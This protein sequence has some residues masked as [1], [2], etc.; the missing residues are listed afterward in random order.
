M[1]LLSIAALA[2]ILGVCHCLFA[3]ADGA[4]LDD[5]FTSIYHADH[6]RSGPMLA[7][8]DTRQ[9]GWNEQGRILVYCRVLGDVGKSARYLRG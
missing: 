5:R 3:G 1:K 6:K 9:P 8:K 2:A 4:P 7:T